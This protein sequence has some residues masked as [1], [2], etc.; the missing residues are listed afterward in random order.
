MYGVFAFQCAMFFSSLF[1]PL[2]VLIGYLCPLMG[3]L[4]VN[5][6]L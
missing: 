6:H 1:L 2:V 3:L 5:N 4:Y